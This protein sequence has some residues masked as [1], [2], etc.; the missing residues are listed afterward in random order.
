MPSSGRAAHDSVRTGA[1]QPV[2]HP[3]AQ[4]RAAQ[5]SSDWCWQDDQDE[6]AHR[7][8]RLLSG[9]RAYVSPAFF[10]R[11]GDGLRQLLN[12]VRAH[13]WAGRLVTFTLI[14]T[15]LSGSAFGLLWWRL[16]EGP[17]GFDVAT[18]WLTAAIRDN[19]SSDYA[20][21]IGGTQIERA[22]RARIAVRVLDIVVRDRDQQIVATAPKA[23][24]RISGMSLL[25]G[26][27]R[28]ESLSLV[29]AELSVLI[30]QD[31]RVS[32]S[33]GAT[34]RPLVTATPTD[35]ASPAPSSAPQIARPP[36][37]SGSGIDALLAALARLDGMSASG[38]NSYDLSEIGIKN[39]NIVV[40]DRQSGNHWSFENITLS[41]RR[42]S[43][44][45]IALSVGEENT[46]R[47]WSFR[48]AIGPMVNGVR[49]VDISAERVLI[50]GSPVR[51][52]AEGRV[53]YRRPA[54]HRPPARR[55]RT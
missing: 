9:P 35:L 50:E 10:Y 12:Q 28:A 44:G 23:E 37:A 46:S 15:V 31:G 24:V 3:A 30:E 1:R 40:D 17:I 22:G 42:P 43:G 5:G 45:G 52:S 29:D 48:S 32:V 36:V 11:L 6:A 16:G 47:P 49:S 27:L 34:T 18:P 14:L 21:E 38:L 19:V 8:Q 26:Q 13:R 25:L 53:L 7:A 33:T 4:G 39:G 55:D 51:A 20:V 2:P 41:V 54:D